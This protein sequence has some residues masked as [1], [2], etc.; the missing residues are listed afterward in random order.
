MNEYRKHQILYVRSIGMP[1]HL[2]GK[3]TH[4]SGAGPTKIKVFYIK[5]LDNGR[6]K[7]EDLRTGNICIVETKYMEF[8][9]DSE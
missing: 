5:P 8:C 7:V 3:L 9:N 4:L 1:D 2:R 6:A